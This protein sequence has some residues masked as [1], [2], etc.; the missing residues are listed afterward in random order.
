MTKETL[1]EALYLN[2]DIEVLKTLRSTQERK[3]WTA[4]ANADD[5]N[6]LYIQSTTLLQDFKDFI[7]AELDKLNAEFE[8]L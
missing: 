7:A 6:I 2:H 8:K 3:H 1:D 5:E 4:F